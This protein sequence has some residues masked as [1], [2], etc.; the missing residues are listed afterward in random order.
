MANVNA[1]EPEVVHGLA[2][3]RGPP[4]LLCAVEHGGDTVVVAGEVVEEHQVAPL[5]QLLQSIGLSFWE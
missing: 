3:H 4:L 2:E 5:H 1:P